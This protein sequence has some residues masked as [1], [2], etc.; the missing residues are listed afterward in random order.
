MIYW[1]GEEK[2]K[3]GPKTTDI[4]TEKAGPHPLSSPLFDGVQR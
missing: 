2:Y 3:K 4:G 1:K